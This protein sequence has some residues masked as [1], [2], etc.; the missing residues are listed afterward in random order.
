[1]VRKYKQAT[2]L[3][4]QQSHYDVTYN[5]KMVNSGANRN[6]LIQ[7]MRM[8]GYWNTN[9]DLPNPGFALN[10]KMGMKVADLGAKGTKPNG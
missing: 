1:M 9:T 10:E 2:N 7:W 3:S 8:R 6:V 5:G 4:H